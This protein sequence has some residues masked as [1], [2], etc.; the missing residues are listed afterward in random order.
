[1][2]SHYIIPP[3]AAAG[4]RGGAAAPPPPVIACGVTFENRDDVIE[5]TESSLGRAPRVNMAVE[6]NLI[7]ANESLISIEG[8]VAVPVS[9]LALSFRWQGDR[10]TLPSTFIEQTAAEHDDDDEE[11]EEADDDD[12]QL[13]IDGL[14]DWVRLPSVSD[15]GSTTTAPL[16]SLLTESNY[17][18]LFDTPQ[19]VSRIVGTLIKSRRLPVADSSVEQ[20]LVNAGQ[21]K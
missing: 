10:N 6:R 12:Q 9:E 13:R 21:D 14:A 1:M 17:D 2:A 19:A 5:S 15:A 18:V 11:E 3:A 8:D 16:E 7:L 20:T 4:A